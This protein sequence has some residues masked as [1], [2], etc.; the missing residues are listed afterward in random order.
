MEPIL[1]KN[2]QLPLIVLLECK[3]IELEVVNPKNLGPY[4]ISKF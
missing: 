3:N 4:N 1:L 2:A